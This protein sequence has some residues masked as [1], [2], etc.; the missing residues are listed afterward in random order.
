MYSW[1]R[2]SATVRVDLF[3]AFRMYTACLKSVQK[4]PNEVVCLVIFADFRVLG[5]RGIGDGARTRLPSESPRFSPLESIQ[6][7]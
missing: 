1:C 5:C 4:V 7:V 3:F 2:D 6:H